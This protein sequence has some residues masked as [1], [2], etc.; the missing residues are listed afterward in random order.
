MRVLKAE[1]RLTDANPELPA[2][3]MTGDRNWILTFA[4]MVFETMK[5]EGRLTDEEAMKLMN[6]EC[7]RL[8]IDEFKRISKLIKRNA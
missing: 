2:L 6:A 1:L 8:R 7:Q 3:Y 5:R 4:A